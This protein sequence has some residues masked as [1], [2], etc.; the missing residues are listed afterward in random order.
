MRN[1]ILGCLIILQAGLKICSQNNPLSP[2]VPPYDYVSTPSFQSPNVASLGKYGDIP[3]TLFNGLVNLYIPLTEIRTG[4]ISVPISISYNSGGVRVDQRPSWVGLSWSLNAG[5]TITRQKK[6]TLDESSCIGLDSGVSGCGRSYSERYSTLT[7]SNWNTV[8]FLKTGMGM[9]TGDLSPDEFYFSI[10]GISG[11][12]LLNHLGEWVVKSKDVAFVKVESVISTNYSILLPTYTFI[13]PRAYTKF[14]LTNS[15]G[16]KYIFGEKS[17]AIEFSYPSYSQLIESWNVNPL[18][19]SEIPSIGNTN[20]YYD[21]FTTAWHLI[22]IISPKGDIVDLNYNTDYSFQQSTYTKVS[23][24]RQAGYATNPPYQVKDYN[25]TS[26][27][28]TKTSYL[29]SIIGNNG[30]ECRFNKSLANDLKFV[31][32]QK[33]ISYD[34]FIATFVS[35]ASGNNNNV[36]HDYKLDG[37]EILMNNSPIKK[38]SLKYFEQ[39]SQR[40]KLQRVQF[41]SSINL[42]IKQQYVIEYNSTLLPEYNTGRED[43]WG[44]F[45][46]KNY[47]NSQSAQGDPPAVS[48]IECNP[49]PYLNYFDSRESNGNVMDAESIKRIT[50]PTGGYTIFIFEPNDYNKIVNYQNDGNVSVSQISSSKIAGGLRISRIENYSAIDALPEVKQYYY[51]ANFIQG[52]NQSSGVLAGLPT[53]IDNGTHGNYPYS[54]FSSSSINYS[55]TSG[56]NHVTYSQVTEDTGAGYIVYDYTN[57]DNG[58]SDK[59]SFA[60]LNTETSNSNFTK[61]LYGNLNIERGLLLRKS[62]YNTDKLMLEEEINTYNSDP[63]RYNKYARSIEVISSPFSLYINK[64]AFPIYYFTSYLSSR[65]LNKYFENGSMTTQKIENV[66]DTKYNQLK[67]TTIT[68]VDGSK[69]LVRFKYSTDYDLGSPGKSDVAYGIKEL[70]DKNIVFSPIEKTETLFKNNE[71]YVIKSN[72]FQYNDLKLEKIFLLEQNS[73]LKLSDFQGSYV[74]N[75]EFKYDNRYKENFHVSKYNSVGNIL[76]TITN[77]IKTSYMWSYRNTHP[78]AKIINASSDDVKNVLGSTVFNNIESSF[79]NSE[80]N[81]SLETLRSGLQNAQI[82]TCLYTPGIGI[83]SE[84]SANGIIT[85][86][87]YDDYGRLKDIRDSGLNLLKQAKYKNRDFRRLAVSDSN[88]NFGSIITG[89]TYNKTINI[90]NS[91]NQPLIISSITTSSAN[92]SH[93]NLQPMTISPDE[94]KSFTINLTPNNLGIFTGSLNINSNAENSSEIILINGIVNGTKIINIPTTVNFTSRRIDPVTYSVNTKTITI[95]NQGMET[96]NVSD[97]KITAGAFTLKTIFT[98]SIAPG[99]SGNFIVQFAV[100]VG[101]SYS[102]QLKVCSNKSSG[103]D[104]ITLTGVAN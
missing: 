28:I 103:N 17:E 18:Y 16:I 39:P 64:V 98:G 27:V 30:L 11:S 1:L 62:T 91:G 69:N 43:H 38:I 58:Y 23:S 93:N 51:K 31:F 60:Q 90:T 32:K 35:G 97:I 6:G 72:M 88:I 84:K 99:Q 15:D 61:K 21:I 50:Y 68:G 87:S 33:P 82:S 73:N 25:Q 57:H 46:D 29:S 26:K 85:S 40:L 77:G 67:S 54:I 96:L 94:N 55:D 44:F 52:G 75:S 70:F 104:I 95:L 13:I 83:T 37:L 78:I 7:N 66:Y 14:I 20:W 3:L 34:N 42:S 74:I 49:T 48:S 80:I 19:A 59:P 41:H 4:D 10:N 45:N 81:T 63:N 22:Q 71:E 36:W 9:P 8:D 24:E 101:G 12:F 89:F 65:T 92:I 76:E 47:Y 79:N 53:Y 100:P 102:G 5:G 2:R 86:Y 56:G